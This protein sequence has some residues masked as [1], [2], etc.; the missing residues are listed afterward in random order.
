MRLV[1]KQLQ[2]N[3]GVNQ[4]GAVGPRDGALGEAWGARGTAD[5][6]WGRRDTEPQPQGRTEATGGQGGKDSYGASRNHEAERLTVR[7]T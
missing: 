6:G 3:E 4:E 7:E 1:K 2:S 5:P